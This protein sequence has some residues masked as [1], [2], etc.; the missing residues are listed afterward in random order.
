M[1]DVDS[2]DGFRD[3][4]NM[5]TV[6]RDEVMGEP[7]VVLSAREDEWRHGAIKQP[8]ACWIPCPEVDTAIGMQ[9]SMM[10]CI[11][12]QRCIIVCGVWE[13]VK[14]VAGTEHD[15]VVESSSDFVQC[16]EKFGEEDDVCVDEESDVCGGAI[17]TSNEGVEGGEGLEGVI[18]VWVMA[19]VETG[20]FTGE[21]APM[22]EEGDGGT[23]MEDLP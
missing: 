1:I 15:K 7:V 23:G 20:C 9:Y 13:C 19:H 3:V 14:V 4:N 17:G 22:T 6:G 5:S 21:F 10:S 2:K 12:L 18:D 11:L 8:G 16:G